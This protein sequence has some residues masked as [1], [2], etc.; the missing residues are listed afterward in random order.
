MGIVISFW[1]WIKNDPINV[2]IATL[3]VMVSLAII[4]GV[5]ELYKYL[6]E[7]ETK[8]TS[9]GIHIEGSV[10]A[11]RDVTIQ[12]IQTTPEQFDALLRKRLKEVMA[13]LPAAEAERRKALLNELDAIKAKYDNLQKAHD[14]QKAKLAEAYKALDDFKRELAP[15]QINQAQ[16]ALALARSGCTK[17]STEPSV[18]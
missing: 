5:W 4:K 8:P 15:E 10:T 18:R 13:E 17:D 6:S 12:Q 3:L 11:G 9:S 16:R 2:A 14:E 1:N 7:K